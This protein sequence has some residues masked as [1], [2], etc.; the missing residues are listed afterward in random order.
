M[1]LYLQAAV[2]SERGVLKLMMSPHEVHML[3]SILRSPQH[4]L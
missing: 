4:K 1:L 2:I 3:T